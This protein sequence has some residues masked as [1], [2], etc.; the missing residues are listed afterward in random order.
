MSIRIDR[1]SYDF[2]ELIHR[3]T[4]RYQTNQTYY[5]KRLKNRAPIVTRNHQYPNGV[6]GIADWIKP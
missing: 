2:S 5:A 6:Y 4:Q 1:L 3:S